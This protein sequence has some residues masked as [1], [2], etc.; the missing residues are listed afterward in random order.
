MQ[1]AL[2]SEGS[3][4]E[5]PTDAKTQAGSMVEIAA[6]LGRSIAVGAAERDVN[7]TY[8]VDQFQ[9]VSA[10]G[11]LKMRVPVE[12]GG[13]ELPFI[14]TG[15]IFYHLGEADPNL[16]QALLPHVCLMEK[17]RIYANPDQQKHFF[18]Q[19]LDGQ[20]ITNATAELGGKIVGQINTRVTRSGNGIRLNGR[21]YYCTGS[22][23]ADAFYILCMNEE[24]LRCLAIVPKDRAGLKVDD[25]WDG[26]GQRTTS[27]GTVSLDDVELEEHE[28]I[29]LNGAGLRH[30]HEGALAQLLHS[31]IDGGIASAALNDA[32]DFGRNR[33]RAVPEAGVAR[34]GDDPYV[35][36][37]IG[38]MVVLVHGAK[39][40]IDRA[41]GVMDTVVP[42]FLRNEP[43]DRR[44]GEASIAVAEAK[45]AS[46]HAALRVGEMIYRIGGASAT[47]RALNFDRHWR[48]AR[49]HTT[50]DPV[51][52]KAKIVGD[53][54]LNRRLPPIS[55]K[56]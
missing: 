14:D 38:E 44:L 11:L 43:S 36:H 47:S 4:A 52:Y 26:M 30:T 16:T 35:Q 32:I 15:R 25:D 18:G 39:A 13:P 55:T 27:S 29:T 41:A 45:M 20:L 5:F 9:A 56:Y 1:D 48:N 22:A 6:E 42:G 19:V 37:T 34:A 3:R 53:F 33:A 50:H 10:S 54:Y 46:E 23:F 49:T 28:V 21:K 51:S 40:L 31:A 24:G 7:R 2:T 8:P 12:Y 17:L